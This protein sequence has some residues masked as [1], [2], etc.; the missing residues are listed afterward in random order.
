MQRKFLKQDLYPHKAD[1][2]NEHEIITAT[3]QVIVKAQYKIISSFGN[4]STI[5]STQKFI[6]NPL[7][8]ENEVSHLP[9]EFLSVHYF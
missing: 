5:T 8:E 6:F 1:W 7:C 2:L 3:E 4:I 9:E